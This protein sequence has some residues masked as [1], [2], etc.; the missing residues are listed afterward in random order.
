ML[1]F[2]IYFYLFFKR[3]GCQLIS[4]ALLSIAGTV[5]LLESKKKTMT[6]V[7]SKEMQPQKQKKY[8]TNDSKCHLNGNGDF[9]KIPS[10]NQTL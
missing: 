6:G 5:D 10:Q 4:R 9:F 1:T 2:I 3:T 8:L 7:K